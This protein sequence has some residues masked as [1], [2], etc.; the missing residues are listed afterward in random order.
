MT[1]LVDGHPAFRIQADSLR[2]GQPKCPGSQATVT[3]LGSLKGKK[4]DDNW[5]LGTKNS[6]EY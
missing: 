5:N 3:Y 6:H 2:Q 1:L 4:V